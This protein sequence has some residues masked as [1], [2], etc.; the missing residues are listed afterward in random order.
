MLSQLLHPHCMQSCGTEPAQLLLHFVPESAWRSEVN[1]GF[2][3]FWLSCRG[4]LRAISPLMERAFLPHR[5]WQGLQAA[6]APA[7][8]GWFIPLFQLSQRKSSSAG[9]GESHRCCVQ[10]ASSFSMVCRHLNQL[11]LNPTEIS[12]SDAVRGERS[13]IGQRCDISWLLSNST[14]MLQ[15]FSAGEQSPKARCLR[16]RVPTKAPLTSANLL[17]SPF[18]S[19]ERP[20]LL[21]G[22]IT[23]GSTGHWQGHQE[24]NQREKFL[25]ANSY[26]WRKKCCDDNIALG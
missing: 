7:G 11:T 13:P 20:P 10:L 14:C 22:E 25:L 4:C 16:L 17:L 8:E 19:R 6:C 15:D 23:D 2:P 24:N 26:L 21:L 1:S 9:L 3:L 12:A 18:S 5:P